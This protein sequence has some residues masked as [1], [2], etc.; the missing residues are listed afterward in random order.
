MV[1]ILRSHLPYKRGQYNTAAMGEDY[2]IIVAK[3]TRA[4][5]Q[6]AHAKAHREKEN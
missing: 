3:G 6:E 2:A 4:S 1:I 5:S